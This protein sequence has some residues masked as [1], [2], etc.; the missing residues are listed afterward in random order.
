MRG[1]ERFNSITDTTT[2]FAQPDESFPG[3]KSGVQFLLRHE[4]R[5]AEAW[6][7][8]AQRRIVRLDRNP[9][10]E[11]TPH[12]RFDP[13]REEPASRPT[14]PRALNGD[15]PAVRAVSRLSSTG[16]GDQNPGSTLPDAAGS[17]RRPTPPESKWG[18]SPSLF[19]RHPAPTLD[20]RIARKHWQD[21]SNKGSRQDSVERRADR[22]EQPPQVLLPGNLPG[23]SGPGGDSARHFPAPS[24]WPFES[25]GGRMNFRRSGP[26]ISLRPTPQARRSRQTEPCR[27]GFGSTVS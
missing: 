18:S 12:P 5:Q 25:P 21:P 1:N 9:A 15:S 16:A 27:K 7:P 19:R 10:R 26:P 24:G 4:I 2:G 6:T 13:H 14:A 3:G 11:A 20:P 17:S 8:L 22:A 23:A